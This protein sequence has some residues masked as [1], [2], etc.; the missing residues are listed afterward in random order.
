M[1]VTE[2]I[3]FEAADRIAAD[4]DRPTLEKVRALVGGSYRTL[5]PALRAWK[6]RRRASG[7]PPAA[8]PPPEVSER[9]AASAASLWS[10]ALSR[11]EQRLQAERAALRLARADAEEARDE[12]AQ[13][14]DRLQ[15]DLEACQSRCDRLADQV[16]AADRDLA[17]LR[18]ERDAASQQ[19]LRATSERDQAC[20]EAAAAQ[21]RAAALRQQFDALLE[22]LP[23]TAD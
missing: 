16:A 10:L 8:K 12:A 11:A 14:A 15:A 18:S 19:A 21:G 1:P 20:R 5:S 6:D 22:R 9:A 4:G 13:L 7:D 17:V 3:V 23:P 2:K